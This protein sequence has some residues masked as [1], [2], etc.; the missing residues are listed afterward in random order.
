MYQTKVKVVRMLR[1]YIAECVFTEIR[2]QLCVLY[3]SILKIECHFDI[4]MEDDCFQND[5]CRV[6]S[7]VFSNIVLIYLN[8][9][10][11]SPNVCSMD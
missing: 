5:K 3:I 4:K 6:K 7:Y 10:A 2:L 9:T 1:M 8:L 11:I